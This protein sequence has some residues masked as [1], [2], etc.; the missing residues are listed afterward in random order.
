MPINAE[1]LFHNN[2][3][4]SVREAILER[5]RNEVSAIPEDNLLSSDV[6]ALVDYLVEKFKVEVP[7]LILGETTATE[8]ERDVQIRD[9]WTNDIANVTGTAFDFSIPFTGD[10]SFF[11]MR[12]N[13]YDSG[14]P[15]GDIQ[16][17]LLKFSISGR[18]LSEE[19]IKQ[20]YEKTVSSIEKYLGWHREFW[21]DLNQLVA[22]SVR[23]EIERRRERLINQKK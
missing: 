5:A 16:G 1:I 17:N 7:E 4:F 14:P 13:T 19:K 8:N 9:S 21:R 2:D 10:S 11:L 12:P 23:P 18:D 22:N 20:S 6:S 3:S 15:Y